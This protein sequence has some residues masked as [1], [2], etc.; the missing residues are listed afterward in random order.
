MAN[1]PLD[2]DGNATLQFNRKAPKG[3]AETAKPA[4][5]EAETK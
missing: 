4:F 3:G 2:N 5:V 1:R